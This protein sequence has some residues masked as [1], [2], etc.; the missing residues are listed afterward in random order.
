MQNF[1]KYFI[2]CN[3]F[4]ELQSLDNLV[5]FSEHYQCLSMLPDLIYYL[6]Y[7]L[8]WGFDHEKGILR[9]HLNPFSY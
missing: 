1:A 2:A 8:D 7:P 4:S 9:Y 6:I 3:F 5:G